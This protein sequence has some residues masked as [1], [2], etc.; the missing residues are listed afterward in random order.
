MIIVGGGRV[1]SV[2]ARS[3]VRVIHRDQIVPA[4]APIVLCTQAGHLDAV[5]GTWI[6][7]SSH[8]DVV[9]VQNGAIQETLARWNVPDATQ[10]ILWFAAPG[11]GE[12]STNRA[13]FFSGKHA[14][15]M[16]EL[17]RGLGIPAEAISAHR[18]RAEWA[19]KMLWN[20]IFG[21]LG[22]RDGGTVGDAAEREGEVAA[23]VAELSTAFDV[24]LDID[25]VTGRLLAY[26][27]AISGFSAR[28]RDVDFRNGWI[29]DQARRKGISTPVHD[30]AVRAL[31]RAEI[32]SRL[33]V[34]G[35]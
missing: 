21:L 24:T 23:M 9:F 30:A 14:E 5:L 3:G 1:G 33:C 18:W 34:S 13:S 10:G 11:G 20:A 19:E 15:A 8:A 32:E 16:V 27:R 7:A 12:W 17:C 31:G 4:E 6:P 2:F 25:A 35:G 22:E 28:L 29:L 26:S